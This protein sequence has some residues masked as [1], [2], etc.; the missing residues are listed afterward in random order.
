LAV[1]VVLRFGQRVDQ[2]R[3]RLRLGMA[4]RLALDRLQETGAQA[5]DGGLSQRNGVP[6]FGLPV[7]VV[8]KIHGRRIGEHDAVLVDGARARA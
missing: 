5:H 1:G 3:D 4:G 7:Q 8:Q 6:T 2:G